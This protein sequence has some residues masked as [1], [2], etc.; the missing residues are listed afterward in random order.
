MTDQADRQGAELGD[1]ELTH[2]LKGKLPL[3]DG[4]QAAAQ[5]VLSSTGLWLVAADVEPSPIRIDV[6]AAQPLRYELGRL[7][8]RLVVGEHELG[9]PTGK[10]ASVQQAIATARLRGERAGALPR[11]GVFLDG[12]SAMHDAWL[13]GW[14]ADD[15]Q[16]LAWLET[17]SSVELGSDIGESVTVE[18]CFVLSSQRAALVAVGPLGDVD[19]LELPVEP[20][21][22]HKQLGRDRIRCGEAEWRSAL[23]NEGDYAQIAPWTGTG[24]AERMTTV[25]RE[26][27]RRGAKQ[28][29]EAER[30]RELLRALVAREDP[31]AA[32]TLSA[33]RPAREATEQG[34]GEAVPEAE[35]EQAQ[36]SDAETSSVAEV[37][38]EQLDRALRAVLAEADL[39]ERLATWWTDWTISDERAFELVALLRP[40]EG[41][42]ERCLALH[43]QLR[44]KLLD[45]DKDLARCL[46]LDLGL[47]D[48]L[49]TAGARARAVE[50]LEGAWERL[51]PAEL[52]DLVPHPESA[53]GD[54]AAVPHVGILE[55]LAELRGEPDKP[56]Q[57]SLRELAQLQPLRRERIE[58]LIQA[59]A[60][61]AVKQRAEQLLSL[62]S[63]GGLAP[64][65]E[66]E[67][68]QAPE[69]ALTEEQLFEAL[70][71][72]VARKGGAM[73]KLQAF[74]AEAE[75][76]DH[77]ALKSFCERLLPA[78]SQPAHRALADAAVAFGMK[79]V[80]AYVSRGDKSVGL[81]GYEGQPSFLLV[82]GDHLD[83]ESPSA[84]GPAELRFSIATELAHLR[85]GH[86]RVTS[87]EVWAGAFEK[88]KETVG[89]LLG[90]MP[91]LKVF[92]FGG[93]IASAAE[94]LQHDALGAVVGTA[95]RLVVP[96][97]KKDD[98]GGRSLDKGTEQLVAA[99]R[100]TQLTADRAGLLLA[101]DVRAAVRAMLF[102]RPEYQTELEL[103]ER[104]GLAEVVS[105][106]DGKG[107]LL[108]PDLVARVCALL[109]FFLSEDFDGLQQALFE[110]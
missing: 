64:V 107:E 4:A 19:W 99:H 62:L 32:I 103:A 66:A 55:Q 83:G 95:S 24:R 28:D 88:G 21:E 85:F 5:L 7:G 26:C 51:P 50:V 71:H 108:Y 33:I 29:A 73:G 74:L 56:H 81:R 16:L 3:P 104:R 44:T 105:R 94:I 6:L 18:R 98:S 68:A 23:S 52:L 31:W 14:L 37:S 82:G 91:A 100:V 96:T 93:R 39:S 2:K 59:T 10:G 49:V 76:P 109:S 58:T 79:A 106:R 36:P 25:A 57:P 89:I 15:E 101:G 22:I 90:V 9:I 86:A 53:A 47:V 54:S 30:A 8:D 69:R 75:V 97:T 48:T 102:S 60:E 43:E 35:G 87:G 84:L 40:L 67:P 45:G 72:P 92:K 17:A 42:A 38:A 110:P 63:V 77:S 11:E 80:E 13:S 65:E 70:Q 1:V 46:E 61:P 34:E 27:W 41:G 12:R 78:T 20:L